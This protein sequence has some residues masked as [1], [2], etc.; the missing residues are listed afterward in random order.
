MVETVTEAVFKAAAVVKGFN[1]DDLIK[2]IIIVNW[3]FLCIACAPEERVDTE[4]VSSGPA[5]LS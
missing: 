5:L 3:G 2:V 4:V 1:K